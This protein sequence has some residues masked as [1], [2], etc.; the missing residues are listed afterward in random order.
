MTDGTT[1]K[2]E[3]IRHPQDVVAVLKGTPKIHRGLRLAL[4]LLLVLTSLTAQAGSLLDAQTSQAITSDTTKCLVLIHGWNPG[5]QSDMFESSDT[6][7]YLKNILLL[8]FA[9]TGWK[10]A[11]YG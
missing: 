10:L 9:G 6:L 3:K 4:Q 1:A 5:N 8:R 7:Y 2:S 11:T